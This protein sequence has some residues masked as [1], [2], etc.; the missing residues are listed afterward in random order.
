MAFSFRLFRNFDGHGQSFGDLSVAAISAD[1]SQLAIYASLR[2]D[3]TLVA[4][5]IN[6]TEGPLTSAVNL[7]HLLP[8]GPGRTFVYGGADL[9]AIHAGAPV[10]FSSQ[11]GATLTLPA[12][13]AT[14][15]AVTLSGKPYGVA[16]VS[17]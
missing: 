4:V 12:R 17:H 13:S 5:L 6:K 14:V 16:P 11:G 9:K 1:Q 10:T 2:R 3:D 8:S 7:A 15:V